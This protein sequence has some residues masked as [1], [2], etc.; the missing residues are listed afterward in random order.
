MPQN[1]RLHFSRERGVWMSRPRDTRV[2]RGLL[3][4]FG[5]ALAGA[6]VSHLLD[7][8]RGRAR[9]ARARDRL[10]ATGRRTKRSMGRR[11]RYAAGQLEGAVHP[12][13]H[14]SEPPDDTTLVQK[15]RS[16]VMG[17]PQFADC[18]VSV[19]A[20][21]GTLHLRG[22]VETQRA[23]DDLVRAVGGVAGVQRV[24]NHL[25]LPGQAAPNKAAAR[26]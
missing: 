15:V 3:A 11:A 8:E 4:G 7:P 9:R 17:R 16:E 24:E 10:L 6:T 13:E 2:P 18:L 23:I 14:W 25:H 20:A 22:Q 1:R 26:S 5:G 12:K 19:D 21:R